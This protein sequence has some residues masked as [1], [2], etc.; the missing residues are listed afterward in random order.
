[1]GGAHP[2][3]RRHRENARRRRIRRRA[4]HRRRHGGHAVRLLAGSGRVLVRGGGT[5]ARR[6]GRHAEHHGEGDRAAQP[7]V[8]PADEG[9]RRRE[10]AAVLR[11]EPGR[12]GGAAAAERRLPL[13]FRGEDRLRVRRGFDGGPGARARR[14]R[15]AVHPASCPAERAG[16]DREQRG[17]GDGA[18]GAVQPPQAALR[19]GAVG[20]RVRERLRLGGVGNHGAH[21]RGL[22]HCR[23]HRVRDPLPPGQHPGT[24]FHEAPPGAFLRAC[25]QG[26]PRCGRHVHRRGRRL[27]LPHLRGF[28]SGGRRGPSHGQGAGVGGRLPRDPH[29]RGRGVPGL[30]RVLRVGD[31]GLHEPGRHALH[32]RAPA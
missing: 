3:A 1:M 27:L 17:A 24:L 8:R 29:V 30:C 20:R 12:R 32:R 15:A 4:G 16:A 2:E 18:P 6:V 14:L 9:T 7:R 26:R 5:G 31:A 25:A 10:R 21:A 22:H 19:A 13:R 11:G 23:A 28:P